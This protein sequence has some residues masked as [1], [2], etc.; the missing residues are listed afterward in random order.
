MSEANVNIQPWLAEALAKQKAGNLGGALL[1]YRRVLSREPDHAEAWCSLGAVLHVLG[2]DG[3]ALEACA[4]A[5]ALAPLN[6]AAHTNLGNVLAA[7]GDLDGAFASFRQALALDPRNLPATAS[8]AGLLGRL[9]HLEEALVGERLAL[10]MAPEDPDLNLN[11]CNTLMR[12]GRLLEAEAGLLAVLGR[13]PGLAK[14][15]WNLAYLR[16]LQGRFLEA[17]PDFG[18][19]LH[20]PL[21]LEN[22]RGFSEP[23]WDGGPFRGRTLLVWIEQGL[24]DTFQFARYLPRV[25]A[26]GG[27]VHFVAYAGLLELM[28]GLPGVD[29]LFS[30]HDELPPF[31][32]QVPLMDLPALF[33]STPA[34]FPPPTPFR[35]AAGYAPPPALA[36]LLEAPGRKGGL[37]WAGSPSHQDNARRSMDPAL[38]APLAGVEGM[39]WMSLQLGAAALPPL[40]GLLDLAPALGSWSDTAHALARLDCVV[41]VDTAV[42]HLAASMGVPTHL[43]LPFFPD[44]RWLMAG[45]AT[46]W[47][48]AMTLHRQPAPGDWTSAVAEAAGALAGL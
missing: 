23:A 11:L 4:R 15:R 22:L 32:L 47:Y 8:F 35:P 24:G 48:P 41:T 27:T 2:R 26:L 14:A 9:G 25:K 19:R 46:A 16:L 33:R 36:A 42:A 34:D 20:V 45:R 7:T 31:D 28:D 10:A 6:P 21:G 38:L 1:V 39:G 5:L 3:E 17:W 30:E 29:R 43:L 44:W 13:T 18:A 40:P 12:L 37:V